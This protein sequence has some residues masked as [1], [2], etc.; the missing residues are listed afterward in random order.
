MKENSQ[1]EELL[2]GDISDVRI[3]PISNRTTRITKE[4]D[5]NDK[6]KS[7]KKI[8]LTPYRFFIVILYFLLNFINGM[9]WVTFASIAAKFGKFYHLNHFLVDLFSL[10][11]MILYPIGCIPEAYIIDNISMRIGLTISAI[12]LIIG[13][14]LK[15]FINASIVFAYIGQFFTAVFQ[16]AI[17][18][19]PGKIASTWFNEKSRTLVTSICCVSNTIGIM[20]GYLIHSFVI[21]ENV[22][23][24]K[25]FKESFESYLLVEFIITIVFC[26]L[27]IF[28]FRNKPKIPPSISQ[29]NFRPTLL[30]EGITKLISNI[31]FIKI[32]ISLTCIV[33][34]INIFG[35]IFNSYMALYSIKDITA[36][37]T[38]AISNLAGILMALI[39][40]AI[41]D[42]S[43]KYKLGMIICNIISLVC[44][45]VT[46]ILM[47]TIAKKNLG[48]TS[49][50]CYPFVIGVT[51]PIYTSGMDFVCEITYPVGESIS[52]GIIMSF[53]QIMGIIGII[54]CDT[55][56]TYLKMHKFL[57][58]VF[59]ILLFSISLISLF[60]VNS[61]LV[62][63]GKDTQNK[64]NDD[65]KKD[66]IEE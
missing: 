61:E 11:F 48:L 46:T 52:E 16:P 44:L 41:I 30:K 33:G 47:E 51:V 35:T 21:E 17:L 25:I 31:N 37:I 6:N 64:S 39:V 45:I 66:L 50:I 2:Q 8:G 24:P 53:N 34:F 14:L 13:S 40:G 29:N 54:I 56:R 12:F 1:Q 58:N 7:E 27:F 20:F 19:S 15:I 57:T 10:L 42:K 63:T 55:F 59:C 62:R 36:T 32:L 4:E 49:L 43:K 18:N 26:L 23:N 60:L 22:V 3:N 5:I 28:F 38:A 65:E 9:H